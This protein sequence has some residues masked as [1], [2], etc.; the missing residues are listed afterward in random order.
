M[1]IYFQYFP[2]TNRLVRIPDAAFYEPLEK[3][4]VIIAMW[5]GEHFLLPF[6][7]RRKDRVSVMV[8]LHRDGAIAAHYG[9]F[10]GLKIVRGSGDHGKEFIRKR[11]VSAFI[12]MLRLLKRGENVAMTADVPKL[13]RIV[14]LGI[15]TFALHAALPIV[16]VAMG[17]SRRLRLKNWDR[18]C[19]SLPLG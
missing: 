15:V 19:V 7:R 17:T 4:P 13:P 8:T 14:G 18:T 12:G 3:E 10:L 5:H 2:W 1:G 11:A 16:P 6:F 9:Q